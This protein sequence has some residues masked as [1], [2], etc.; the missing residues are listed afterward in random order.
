MV[1]P[2]QKSTILVFLILVT[3]G[4]SNL[5]GTKLLIPEPFGLIEIDRNVY[6]EEGATEEQQADL[7]DAVIRA[8]KQIDAT[9]GDVVS[10]P[11]IHAC[12]TED[13]Y[14]GFGGMGSRAKVYG[15]QILL[16]PRG[17]N[18]HLLAHEW[19][20]DEIR[21]RLT[22]RAWFYLPQWF[23]EG[24]AVVVSEAPGHSEEH[25]QYLVASDIERPTRDELLT[26]RSLGKW[27]DGVRH[28]GIRQNV[29][30]KAQGM[31]KIR[32]V[33]AAAGHE[34]R[35]WFAE[36]GRQGLLDFIQR[37][38]NGEAFEDVYPVSDRKK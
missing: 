14:T 19:S 2:F 13:C 36:V 21:T 20:H 25:W 3:S 24:L 35:P 38:N 28:Y 26:Y 16:S 30:R 23:D 7:L 6:I 27:L 11:A 10:T 33:Y 32:P 12:V 17:L 34:V 9:Y 29:E 18:W 5:R 31:P 4:C 37:L 1:M 8:R 15:Y 22:F